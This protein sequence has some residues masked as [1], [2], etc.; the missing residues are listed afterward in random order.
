MLTSLANTELVTVLIPM[1]VV[2]EQNRGRKKTEG[3][4]VCGIALFSLRVLTRI[5][6]A[7][8]LPLLNTQIAR[9]WPCLGVTSLSLK[10]GY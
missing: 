4:N 1:V 8:S 5:V 9:P 7:D 10:W 6:V 3:A 2:G